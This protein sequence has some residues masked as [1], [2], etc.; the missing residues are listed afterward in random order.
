MLV[1]VLQHMLVLDVVLDVGRQVFEAGDANVVGVAIGI[2]FACVGVGWPPAARVRGH[3]VAIVA[4]ATGVIVACGVNGLVAI[5]ASWRPIVTPSGGGVV[6]VVTACVCSR[7]IV[8][9]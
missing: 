2:D 4:V 5:G 6:D 1:V 7:P 9:A 8:V 3:S